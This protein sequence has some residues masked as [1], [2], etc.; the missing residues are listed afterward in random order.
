MINFNEPYVEEKDLRYI[1][2]AIFNG[3]EKVNNKLCGDGKYTKL[4]SNWFKDN[5]NIENLLLTTSCSSALDMSAIVLDLKPGDE[6]ILPSY[7]FVS[8]ANAFLLRGAKLVFA[9]VDPKTMNLDLNDVA[10]KM[11]KKTKIICPVHYAGT[12]CD[13]DKLFELIKNTDIKVVEDAAQGVGAFY[14]DKPL[15]TLGD[16][17]CYSFHETKNYVMGEGGAI[18]CKNDEDFLNAEIIREKGTDR[19][20]FI[21]GMVDKYT[22][23]SVGSSY[24]PSELC[25]AL[26]Y[27]QLMK[28]EEIMSKRLHIWNKYYN[29]FENL[30]KEGY[31]IRQYI[32][33]YNSHNAHMFFLILPNQEIRDTMINKLKE[34]NISS[35]F[36]YIPLHT[37]PMGVKLGNKKGSLPI[38]EEFSARL[39]RLPM[40]AGMSEEDLEYIIDTI[41]YLIK[42]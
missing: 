36:H 6:V 10:N 7:T 28:Y 33:E 34:R 41:N 21:R 20:Q 17:G 32:P 22:W 37:S 40:Y 19:S 16:I 42:K 15:G 5:L 39:I 12:S 3:S 30:E 25:V 31:L 13:M 27:S 38:T 9:D 29:A 26:L 8:T 2:D 14:K 18:I 11:T 1:H 23:R 24:L 35:V 4:V